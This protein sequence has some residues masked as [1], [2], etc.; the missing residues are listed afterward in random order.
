MAV[1]SRFLLFLLLLVPLQGIFAQHYIQLIN[2]QNGKVRFF[3][4]GDRVVFGL[5]HLPAQK[6]EKGRIQTISDSGIWI[7]E[8]FIHFDS[9]QF[10]GE[11]GLWGKFAIGTASA[12]TGAYLI[13]HL[14]EEGNT[15]LGQYIAGQALIGTG[16]LQFFI[17]GIKLI[18]STHYDLNNRWRLQVRKFKLEAGWNIAVLTLL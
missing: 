9:L 18:T 1:L 7:R 10:L 11:S 8:R 15:G 13:T 12:I 5:K 16:L 14:P 6:P 4:T 17:S 3:L 2:R